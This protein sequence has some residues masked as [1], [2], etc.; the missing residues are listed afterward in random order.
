MCLIGVPIERG[1]RS[2]RIHTW[3]ETRELPAGVVE[4]DVY[5]LREVPK[6]VALRVV[7]VDG[8]L[9]RVGLHAVDRASASFQK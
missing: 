5:D 9:A 4:L 8:R 1:M 7:R 6:A 2:Y 3:L